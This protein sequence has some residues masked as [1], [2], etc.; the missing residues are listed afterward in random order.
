MNWVVVLYSDMTAIV[1]T[2]T[3]MSRVNIFEREK[4]GR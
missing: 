3:M 2:P 4:G 1:D